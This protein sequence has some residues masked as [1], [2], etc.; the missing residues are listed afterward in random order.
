MS[1]QIFLC[2]CTVKGGVYLYP[3]G[4]NSHFDIPIE[5]TLHRFDTVFNAYLYPGGLDSCFDI[6]IEITLHRFNTVFKYLNTMFL[7]YPPLNMSPCD[8]STFQ[9]FYP[10]INTNTD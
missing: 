2:L 4:L 3:R 9:V 10:N 7:D 6:P 5:I 8:I 1:Q